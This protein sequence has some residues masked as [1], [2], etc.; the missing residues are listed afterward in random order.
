M[1]CDADVTKVSGQPYGRVLQNWLTLRLGG[2]VFILPHQLVPGQ[3]MLLGEIW[4]WVTCELSSIP[5]VEGTSDSVL[6]KVCVGTPQ[7]PL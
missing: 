6:K 7:H 5:T 3:A 2:C 4:S 1:N